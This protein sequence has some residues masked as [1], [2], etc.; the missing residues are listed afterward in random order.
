MEKLTNVVLAAAMASMAGLAHA[1]FIDL[2]NGTVVDTRT[3]RI[4]L[5]DWGSSGEADW[6]TQRSW[7]ATQ[8][9]D[10]K[11]GWVWT[12]GFD[13]LTRSVLLNGSNPF[14]NR[15]GTFWSSIEISY[16]GGMLCPPD[17]YCG[18]GSAA[19]VYDALGGPPEIFLKSKVARAMVSRY[20]YESVP[21]PQTL[22]LGLLG[23]FAL[24]LASRRRQA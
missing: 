6:N 21:A 1:S 22:A 12:Y 4:W 3:H 17:T 15:Y 23:L 11:S 14:V 19:Y 20:D 7:T 24:G 5:K 8:S 18:F 2:N 16:T 9:I 10:G 13:E